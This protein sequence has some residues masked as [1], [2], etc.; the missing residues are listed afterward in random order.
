MNKA[1][2]LLIL[3]LFLAGP[4][5]AQRT[6]GG[7]PAP[8]SD[9]DRD[10]AQQ[11]RSN[12]SGD[13]VRL[14][15]RPEY[16]A[17]GPVSEA[18]ATI[19]TLTAAGAQLARVRDYPTLRRRAHVF[20][21][22]RGLEATQAQALLAQAAPT[23]FVDLHHIYRFAQGSPRL[24]AAQAVGDPGPG[25]CS[26]TG[27]KIGM[28]DGPVDPQHP[29]LAGVRLRMDHV[30]RDGEVAP[31]YDHGTAVASI[32]AGRGGYAGF[33]PGASLDVVIA[34]SSTRGREGADIERITAALDRLLGRGTRLINLSFAGPDNRAMRL[35][36]NAAAARGAVLIAAS[37]NDNTG[38]SAL[39]AAAPEV[40][41]VTAVD[42]GLRPYRRANRGRHI[43]FA[44]PGVDLWTA[45]GGGGGYVTGTSFA[46][47]IVTALAARLGAGA[48]LGV[49]GLRARLAESA[50][51][52]GTPGRDTR[53]GWGLVRA[54]GC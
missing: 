35:A 14:A 32:M 6:G 33:A 20:V 8:S 18:Q 12:S 49:T 40:I 25:R 27:R 38:R 5:A 52:L 43:E 21:F 4:A 54:Q 47:P 44:A 10:S 46:A 15:N 26:G 24:Y 1:I 53:T 11:L 19:G 34:F 16:I 39:P 41:A 2:L 31:N 36:L 51:D 9:D 7:A 3:S 17:L 50:Q 23:T 28:I 29:A 30:L 48:S 13:V 37:G 45:K 22:P 42:A